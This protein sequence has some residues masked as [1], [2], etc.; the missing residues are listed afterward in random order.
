MVIGMTVYNLQT[1]QKY[2]SLEPPAGDGQTAQEYV[3]CCHVSEVG[4]LR[5]V[6]GWDES[7]M[8]ECTNLD[9]TVRYESFAGYDFASLIYADV[10]G[11]ELV[12][13]EVNVF[14]AKGYLVLILPDDEG[15]RL[16]KLARGLRGAAEAAKAAEKGDVRTLPLLYHF[17]WGHLAADYSETLEALEDEMEALSELILAGAGPSQITRIGQLRKAAYTHKKLL[18]AL[19]YI[20][21]QILMDEN[22]LLNKSNA[23]YFRNMSTRLLKLYDFA[24]HL[25]TLS[26]ELLHT[27]DSKT[28]ARLNE[29]MNKLT[30]ITLFFGPLTVITGIYGMNFDRMPELQWPLGYPA[31]LV[32]MAAV[33]LA[34][35]LVMKRKKWL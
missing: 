8:L 32:V 6:F 9:E 11:A 15:P 29:T 23:H 33:S 16:A 19:S 5:E 14:F 4:A 27:Y 13:R 22:H 26:G 31:A 35:Y 1:R 28:A 20:G 7:T 30:V 17:I 12:Q 3:I 2:D 24:D 10:Y 21:G 18:R 34:I 25:Y